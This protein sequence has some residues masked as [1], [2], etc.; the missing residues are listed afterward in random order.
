M[1]RCTLRSGSPAPDSMRYRSCAGKRIEIERLHALPQPNRHLLR[2]VAALFE[3]AIGSHRVREAV[4]RVQVEAEPSHPPALLATALEH[5][6]LL[7][8]ALDLHTVGVEHAAA[9][10]DAVTPQ[11][12][13]QH[14]VGGDVGVANFGVA[15]RA[16]A[17]PPERAYALSHAVDHV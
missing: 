17:R 8:V 2:A 3:R 7:A 4:P 15:V 5:L 6:L 9:D 11:E 10:L 1:R 14:R 13:A 16:T 12:Q